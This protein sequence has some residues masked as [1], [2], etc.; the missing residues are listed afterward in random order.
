MFEKFFDDLKEYAENTSHI[1]SVLVIGSY[2][3]G[4]NIENSDLD[5]EM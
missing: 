5:I 3:R 1:E 4:T 2:A